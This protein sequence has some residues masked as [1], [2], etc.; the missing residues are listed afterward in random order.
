MSDVARLTVDVRARTGRAMA[1]LT[2]LNRQIQRLDTNMTNL[3]TTS[4]SLN[5]SLNRLGDSTNRVGDNARRT[6]GDTDGLN[7]ALRRLTGGSNGA[8]ASLGNLSGMLPRILYQMIALAAV[9]LAPVFVEAAAAIGALTAVLGTAAVSLG[10]FILVAARSE[11]VSDS[12]ERFGDE[13]DAW[14]VTLEDVVAVPI[15]KFLDTIIDNITLLNPLVES[16]AEILNRGADAFDNFVNSDQFTSWLDDINEANETILPNLGNAFAD[17]IVGLMEIIRA[18]LPMGEDFSGGLADMAASFREWSEGLSTNAGFQRFVDWI[19]TNTSIVMEDLGRITGGVSDLFY[20]LKD[21]GMVVLDGLADFVEYVGNLSPEEIQNIATAVGSLYIAVQAFSLLGAI[22]GTITGIASAIGFLSTPLG[23]VTLAVAQLMAGWTYLI[24]VFEPLQAAITDALIPVLQLLWEEL[25][26][27]WVNMQPL[28][29]LATQYAGVLATVLVYAVTAALIVILG[30]IVIIN[31]LIDWFEILVAKTRENWSAIWGILKYFIGYLLGPGIGTIVLFVQMIITHWGT[32]KNGTSEAWNG[33]KGIFSGALNAMQAGL[34]GF[35][36]SAMGLWNALTQGL[37]LL[38]DQA[39]N[40]MINGLSSASNTI[41]NRLD[42]LRSNMI[43]FFGGSNT[44]LF[45]SGQN[46]ING[47]MDGINS[48]VGGLLDSIGDI[49][50]SISDAFSSVLEI[51]S[52]SRVFFKHGEDTI[53]GFEKAISSN[54]VISPMITQVG[55]LATM[56]SDPFATYATAPTPEVLMSTSG[57]S[58][59]GTAYSFDFR[60]A[61]VANGSREVEDMVVSALSSAK[62][63]GRTRGLS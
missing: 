60:G 23:W 29:G 54:A 51:F 20:S 50:G 56:V 38:W 39:W 14:V 57:T 19:S 59:A 5:G 21:V 9:A 31:T 2:A 12:L 1:S 22:A 8:T 7:G 15:E 35:K 49:A 53:G 18:F 45:S 11:R 25:K 48:A 16:T 28:I 13:I 40:G 37:P 17:L 47:L 3:N 62:K 41:L 61:V 26:K 52:P 58:N 34:A 30:F 10:A 55:A 4:D 44:W 46:I 27:L 43:G 42:W 32:I 33:I 36:A 6:A 63:K 24:A